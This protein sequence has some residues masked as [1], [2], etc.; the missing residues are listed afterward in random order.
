MNATRW[1]QI[2]R[3]FDE[4]LRLEPSLRRAYVESLGATDADLRRR[5]EVFAGRA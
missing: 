3:S 1:Q 5:V 2:K 4:V